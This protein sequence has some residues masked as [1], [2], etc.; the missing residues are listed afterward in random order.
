MQALFAAFGL[1]GS[2]ILAQAVNFGIVLIALTYFLYKPINKVLDARQKKVAKG[3]EDA[4][5]AAEKLATADGIASAKLTT[6]ETEAEGIMLSARDA[7]KSEKNRILKEAEDRAAHVAADA[8]ARAK[9]ASAKMLRESEKEVARLAVLAA[10][11]I[12]RQG[13][14]PKAG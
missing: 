4:N 10:E 9:E 6:A 13:H 8:D 3:I 2:L 7:A 11:K 14:S 5:N 1:N 12:L